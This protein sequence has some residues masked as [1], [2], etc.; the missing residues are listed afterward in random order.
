MVEVKVSKGRYRQPED[1]ARLLHHWPEMLGGRGAV[2][3]YPNYSFNAGGRNREGKIRAGLS[4][5][6]ILSHDNLYVALT[7]EEVEL[8][9]N[10][11]TEALF[12][13]LQQDEYRELV[14][15]QGRTRKDELEHLVRSLRRKAAPEQTHWTL[16]AV[17]RGHFSETISI[18]SQFGRIQNFN[19]RGDPVTAVI[20]L[21]RISS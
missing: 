20:G 6:G 10:G 4:R 12:G 17:Q 8:L 7:S 1:T 5:A 9:K 15:D 16:M 2:V 11:E 13:G 14:D 21:V 18:E 19:L 3:N